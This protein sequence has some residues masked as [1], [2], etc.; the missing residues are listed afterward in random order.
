M[1]TRHAPLWAGAILLG[2][3]AIWSAPPH[4]AASDSLAAAIAEPVAPT[5]AL[6]LAID[7]LF[8]RMA[9]AVM[10]GDQRAYLDL[11]DR[12]DPFFHQEQINW[13]KD[14]DR[15]LPAAFEMA[16]VSDP[17]IVRGRDADGS[18]WQDIRAMVEMRYTPGGEGRR[19]EPRTIRYRARFIP[20]PGAAALDAALGDRAE[21]TVGPLLYAGEA[22]EVLERGS[23]R[24]LFA[25]RWRETAQIAADALPPIRTHVD[26][27]MAPTCRTRTRPSSSTAT[28]STSRPRSPLLHRRSLRAG[29]SRARRSRSWPASPAARGCSTTSSPTSTATS[30]RSRWATTPA[31]WRGGCSRASPT[32]LRGVPRRPGDA[33]ADPARDRPIP[34]NLART[35]A[36]GPSRAAARVGGTGR[37]PHRRSPVDAE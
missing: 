32:R 11:I 3:L 23:I 30:R 31:R 17:S 20:A 33:R 6:S 2:Q 8:S 34:E 22:W 28:C 14:L 12:S 4:A 18:P 15:G 16:L 10:A 27:Q 26:L 7:D 19:H 13:A 21:G 9:T 35:P 24:V 37:L 5:R 29:T 36:P 1:D 25:P